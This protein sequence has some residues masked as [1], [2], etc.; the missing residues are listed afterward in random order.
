MDCNIPDYVV[1]RKIESEVY[2]DSI[3]GCMIGGAA[4][5]ALGYPVE[6]S[7]V[8]D[9]R[10]S[11]GP[12]GIDEYE[13]DRRSG[14]ALISDDTQ[15]TLF[16][17]NGL[18][19]GNT[20]GCLRG[21]AAPYSSYIA[22]AYKDWYMTQTIGF[23]D[24][25]SD[26][27]QYTAYMTWLCDVPELFSRRAPG[28]TCLDAL[29]DPSNIRRNDF[30]NPP[31]NNSKGCGGVMRV[32]PLSLI[33]WHNMASLITEAA[34]A[35]AVTHGH[36]LGYMT[37]SVLCYI[38]H[39]IV[40]IEDY[41]I[42]LKKIV[43]EAKEA[44]CDMFKDCEYTSELEDII[45]RAVELSENDEAD[46]DNIK[47]LGAGWVAE[48]A[49]AIAVYCSLRYQND[50][51]SGI[52]AAVNHDGDSDSTGAITGNIL[53]AL[54]GYDAIEEKWKRNL[55]LADVILE[56]ADDLCYGCLM[57]EYSSYKDPAW[58]NKYLFA[59]WKHSEVQRPF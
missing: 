28:N 13:L 43:L 48:E 50:F 53:G 31:I 36:P 5:D 21:I 54:V 29:S 58:E 20:R 46:I 26:A 22:M 57:S 1:R 32:A 45:D 6:F 18:L 25:P 14:K 41:P 8:P 9:I 7:S 24:K 11:H 51:S 56:M 4:G 27:R 2:K 37:A 47:C 59:E 16:T 12:Y 30:I 35:A 19:F 3:R 15:M 10:M 23:K 42:D 40:F 44:V 55:E 52:I 17:A 33:K 39:R 49:L 34:Q 38:I